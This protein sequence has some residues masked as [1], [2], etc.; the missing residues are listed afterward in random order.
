MVRRY[1]GPVELVTVLVSAVI[2][3][4]ALATPV[5]LAWARGGT[6]TMQI[7]LLA[8]N[9]PRAAAIGCIAAVVVA[10]F[11]S[12]AESMIVPW[13]AALCG[14]VV[15]LLN[16]LLGRSLSS[17]APLT[18]LNYID[19]LAG[20]ILLGGL[21]SAAAVRLAMTLAFILGALISVV[22]GELSVFAGLEGAPRGPAAWFIDSPPVWLM[23]PMTVLVVWC[24]LRYRHGRRHASIT[25]ELPL[26]PILAA[27]IGVTVPVLGS[28]WMVRH[29]TTTGDIALVTAASVL[30]ALLAGRLLPGRDGTLLQT[31]IAVASVGSVIV[32]IPL[33]V[34]MVPLSIIGNVAGMWF[35]YRR[36]APVFGML[37]LLALAAFGALAA[38]PGRALP[39][40]A[41]GGMLA[42]TVITGYCFAAAVPRHSPSVMLGIAV[43]YVPGVVIALRGRMFTTDPDLA[44]DNSTPGATAAVVAAGCMINLLILRRRPIAVPDPV[45]APAVT[46]PDGASSG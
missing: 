25:V 28:E 22:I 44:L 34:W 37:A 9:M 29:G 33:P 45:M 1:T 4:L 13:A 19:T 30:A 46:E 35:G 23:W 24:A 5:S 20:G 7:E 31:S 16:H 39:G 32:P 26:S 14:L 42:L 11:A 15:L 18:T 36:A 6:A 12:T 41:I 21:A 17:I 43:L 40:A 10:V 3:G 8:I 38:T 27:V 2:G